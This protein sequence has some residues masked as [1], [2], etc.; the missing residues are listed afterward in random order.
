MYEYM[1]EIL[2]PESKRCPQN[3]NDQQKNNWASVEIY[4]T[5]IDMKEFESLLC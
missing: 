1:K 4:N 5:P 3:L 2:D